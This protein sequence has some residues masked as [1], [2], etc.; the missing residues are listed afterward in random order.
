M[1]AGGSKLSNIKMLSHAGER[2]QYE[3]VYA[4]ALE[5]NGVHW[6]EYSANYQ[7]V[8]GNRTV[9]MA[10]RILGVETKPV[11][12]LFNKHFTFD[13]KPGQKAI[14]VASILSDLDDPDCLEAA[15]RRAT[16]CSFEEVEALRTGHQEWWH[17]YWAASLVEFDD[18]LL[19]QFYYGSQ[20]ILACCTREGKVIPGLFGNW[21]TVDRP[22]WTGG[23][24]L[25]YNY[26]SPFWALLPSNRGHLARSYGDTLLDLIP[27]G[28]AFARTKLDCNG[29]YLPVEI[30]PWG[31]ISC[32]NFLG[33]KGHA[34]FST[35]NLVLDFYYTWDLDFARR[36]YPFLREVADFWA[37]FLVR[38]GDRYVIANDALDEEYDHS[39]D[40]NPIITLALLKFFL[41][42]ILTISKA[43]DVDED[44]AG[45]WRE[46]EEH[47]S[48]YT[49]WEYD[50]KT[51][52]RFT[53]V[54][55][56]WNYH[57]GFAP[58][59]PIGLSA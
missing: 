32:L 40:T 25:N 59:I 10:F 9:G 34:L 36:V 45:K 37:D 26:E 13:L 56:P 23:Y 24:T 4:E 47:L 7:R 18:P 12:D 42:G 2:G 1:T 31:T 43:L 57:R 48:D 21:I 20:Y 55:K 50:G 49:T 41:G 8:P 5:E 28:R 19:E 54:G 15:K 51:L 39:P 33:Q 53:E 14:F 38:D 46:I 29:V 30:G 6:I 52:F 58:F 27:I 17:E 3:R 16:G 44:A 11:D 22:A 35:V